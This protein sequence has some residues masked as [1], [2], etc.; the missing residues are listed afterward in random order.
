MS[1]SQQSVNDTKKYPNLNLSKNYQQNQKNNCRI[2]TRQSCDFQQYH[3]F[4][5]HQKNN[6][7]P[8]QQLQQTHSNHSNHSNQSNQLN[9]LNQSNQLK[10]YNTKNPKFVVK[11][12]KKIKYDV[13][14]FATTIYNNF[15]YI[16]V[17]PELEHNINEIQRLL[18]SND[19]KG[20]AVFNGSNMIAYLIGEYKQLNDGRMVYYISYIFVA[21]RFRYKKIG[22]KL[23]MMSIQKCSESGIRFITLT[24]DTKNKNLFEYY[25]RRS[26]I[27]DPILRNNGRHEILT[28]YL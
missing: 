3:D 8:K 12:L 17:Q 24:C 16:S 7:I 22:S 28:L 1:N 21:P 14:P 9:Q 18:K 2:S 15:K 19:M 23:L 20:F 4:E 10:S 11:E 27:E 25:K 6:K 26:F 13:T 5:Q